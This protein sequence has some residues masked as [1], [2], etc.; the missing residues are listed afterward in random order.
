MEDIHYDGYRPP[1]QKISPKNKNKNDSTSL[2]KPKNKTPTTSKPTNVFE[3][4]WD[5]IKMR[6]TPKPVTDPPPYHNRCIIT[7]A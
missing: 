1:K 3:L 7:Q 5:P 2:A 6:M 4:V